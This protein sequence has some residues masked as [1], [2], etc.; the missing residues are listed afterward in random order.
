[1]LETVLE[2]YKEI[3]KEKDNKK[4]SNLYRQLHQIQD[5]CEHDYK[6]EDKVYKRCEKCD[7]LEYKT[8]RKRKSKKTVRELI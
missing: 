3:E 7:M 2:I 5:D 6:D 8:F 1:M 4:V